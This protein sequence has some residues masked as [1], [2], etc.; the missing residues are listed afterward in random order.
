M[1]T[2]TVILVCALVYIV[3]SEPAPP[4]AENQS[5]WFFLIFGIGALVLLL[6]RVNPKRV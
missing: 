3:A 2:I 5:F 6:K 1:K 4:T